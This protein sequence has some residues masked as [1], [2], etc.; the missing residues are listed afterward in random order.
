MI[1]FFLLLGQIKA[2]ATFNVLT[3]ATAED[4]F[5]SFLNDIPNG[6]VVLVAVKR[7]SQ[8]T[9][10]ALIDVLKSIGAQNPDILSTHRYTLLG[11]KGLDRWDWIQ[12][13]IWSHGTIS[14]TKMIPLLGGKSL[15]RLQ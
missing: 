10:P 5:T 11:Y 3:D 2:Q 6:T 13:T 12:E 9:S 7:S 4:R 15:T 1:L 8:V 14:L